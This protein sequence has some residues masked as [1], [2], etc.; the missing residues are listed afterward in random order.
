MDDIARGLEVKGSGI[1]RYE[2]L[3]KDQ[4]VCLIEKEAFYIPGLSIRLIPPQKIFTALSKGYCKIANGQVTICFGNGQVVD[5]EL[6]LATKLPIVRV[7]RNATEAAEQTMKILY[8][9]VTE[10]VNQNLTPA[11]KL[12]LRWHFRLG[13]ASSVVIKWMTN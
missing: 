13:H 11:Q 1:V 4:T 8:A 3:D 12:L 7:F 9:C 6:D 5:T 2:L 10:N